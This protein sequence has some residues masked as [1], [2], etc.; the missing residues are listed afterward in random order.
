MKILMLLSKEV[1][2]DP[3]V[4]KEAEALVDVGHDVTVL[5]WDRQHAYPLESR[6]N[7]IRVVRVRNTWLMKLLPNDLFRNP[8]WWKMAFLKGKSL[9]SDGFC[10]DI[11][12]C[13]DLDTLPIGVFLARK[14][15]VKLVYDAHEIFGNMIART[16]PSMVVKG[17]FWL[18]KMLVNRADEIITVND[19]L[20]EY[21]RSIS[22]KNITIIM[23]C[24]DLIIDEY[25]PTE[26]AIFTVIYIGVLHRSRMFPEVVDIIGKM[27]TVKFIIAGKRENIFDEVQKRSGGY[28]AVE[29]VGSIPYDQVL[30]YTLAA[31]VVLCMINPMDRNNRMAL[32]NKQFEAMVCGRPIIITK[33]TYAGDLTEKLGCGLVIEYDAASLVE[34]ITTLRDNPSLCNELGR[35]ALQAAQERYSWD[36]E[37][38]K[39][40]DL[41]D[42]LG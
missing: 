4:T 25:R 6:I 31:D 14:F 24:K 26:N 34:A 35:N 16:M 41:Y 30:S 18:E 2:N 1:M 28:A 8:L 17:A 33:H 15:K 36:H 29:F 19:P 12:H 3:R 22:H 5:M 40:R 23:N 11:V 7:G 27:D 21:F 10:F 38:V 20:Y 13:H 42:S 32:A 39:L 9:F 37:K